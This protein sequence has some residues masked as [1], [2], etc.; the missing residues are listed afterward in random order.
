VECPHQPDGAAIVFKFALSRAGV[1]GTEVAPLISKS[2][3]VGSTVEVFAQSAEYH[4]KQTTEI[5]NWNFPMSQMDQG[6]AARRWSRHKID[7]RLKISFPNAGKND[8]TFGRANSLSRGGI[9]AY[10]PCSIPVGTAVR[11]ELTF[12]YSSTE[13]KL[14]A[15]IRTCE[16]FRYGLE[17]TRVSDEMQE[18]IVKNCNGTE[19]LQ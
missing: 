13:A 14:D 10:I 5:T 15:V 4:A 12:P 3:Y 19:L 8:S 7:V 6:P 2:T 17:F 18:M 1:A 9:G 16:G 11:L